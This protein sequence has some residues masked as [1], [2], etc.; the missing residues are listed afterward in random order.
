MVYFDAI[1]GF[2]DVA[3][4]IAEKDTC[5]SEAP[6]CESDVEANFFLYVFFED[7]GGVD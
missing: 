6:V 7:G 3:T 4:V 5:Y 1:S 2:E